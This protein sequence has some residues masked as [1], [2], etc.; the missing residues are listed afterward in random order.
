MNYAT[1]NGTAVAGGDYTAASGT[2]TFGPGELTQTF[3]IPI[4]DDGTI[5]SDET[6]N[7]TLSSA[8]G[9]STLGTLSSGQV[10]IQDNDTP[11]PV[12][13][14]PATLAVN[15]AGTNLTFTVSRA[16]A[17]TAG[18]ISY[19]TTPGTA[20]AGSDFTIASGSV[21]FAA[22]DISKTFTVTLLD[23]S[24]LEPSESF[25]VSLGSPTGGLSLGSPASSTITITDGDADSD[26]MPDDYETSVGLNAGVN[27]AALDLDGD[28]FTNFQEF[29]M[30]TLPSSGASLLR[31][32]AA[33]S[34]ANVVVSFATVAGRTYKVEW[35]LNL[36]NPWT[37][38]EAGIPGTGSV[39]NVP[40]AGA[41]SQ[42]R[43]FYRVTIT[44]P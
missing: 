8:G 4:T 19:S 1:S 36:A 23:D 37:I 2:L 17:G 15:E 26:G 32:E 40:D 38:V 31:P 39:V 41:A 12:T 42:P 34:G 22:A 44:L 28:G 24:T 10:T 30:G 25:T 16:L 33:P 21:T 7:V 5:E 20:A 9:N 35:S 3:A 13:L 29:I 27:D 18:S 11:T 14:S 43:R 6:I